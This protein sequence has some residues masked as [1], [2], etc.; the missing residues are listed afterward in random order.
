MSES[1]CPESAELDYVTSI[2]SKLTEDL[3]ANYTFLQGLFENTKEFVDKH[4]D[5]VMSIL[6]S[7]Q[8]QDS[9]RELA[10]QLYNYINQEYACL[11]WLREGYFEEQAQLLDN[12]RSRTKFEQKT[13]FEFI[14]PSELDRL[15][16]KINPLELLIEKVMKG[17][18]QKDEPQ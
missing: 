16:E 6:S 15:E 13:L 3:R 14:D 4:Y 5:R 11:Y 10:L 12:A 17:G 7:G 8:I 2:K 1:E 9:E 18:E